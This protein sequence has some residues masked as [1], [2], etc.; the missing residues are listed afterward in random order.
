MSTQIRTDE[1]SGR[2]IPA[3]T[4]ANQDKP[5]ARLRFAA[6]HAVRA[7]SP[8]QADRKEQGDGYS[9]SG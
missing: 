4:D 9:D 2:N 1:P 5:A 7:A 8:D 6:S 3:A